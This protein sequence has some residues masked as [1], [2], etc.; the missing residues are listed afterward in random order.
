MKIFSEWFPTP[1]HH[2]DHHDHH[3]HDHHD[4]HDVHHEEHWDRKDT[5][6]GTDSK[7]VWKREQPA[8]QPSLISNIQSPLGGK[9]NAALAST[10]PKVSVK[11]I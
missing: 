5:E 2:H 10:Q 7:V 1:D 11:A 6:S 4:H 9:S 8:A 3:H